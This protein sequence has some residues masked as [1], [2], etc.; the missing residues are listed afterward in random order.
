[1]GIPGSQGTSG[2]DLPSMFLENGIYPGF[3]TREGHVGTNGLHHRSPCHC[4]GWLPARRFP[5]IPGD[6]PRPQIPGCSC[7]HDGPAPLPVPVCTHA[8]PRSARFL[9]GTSTDFSDGK[10]GQASGSDRG[11]VTRVHRS[12]SPLSATDLF[13][14]RKSSS[15]RH[16]HSIRAYLK[17]GLHNSSSA[18]FP[19]IPF[20]MPRLMAARFASFMIPVRISLVSAMDGPNAGRTFAAG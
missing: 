3:S 16:R 10:C 2:H 6:E 1:M 7:R 8:T 15:I 9:Y 14:Q 17:K 5:G 20:R 4:I 19:V 13:Q 11:G 12:L 18:S